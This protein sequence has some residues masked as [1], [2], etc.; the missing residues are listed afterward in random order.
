MSAGK[1]R[2]L[3]P[4]RR[5]AERKPRSG[6]AVVGIVATVGAVV[7][8]TGPG[9]LAYWADSGSMDSGTFGAGTLDLTLDSN[10]GNPT[11]WANTSFALSAMVPGEAVATSFPVQNAGT[12][13]FTYTATATASGALAPYLTF[14]AYV[15]GTATNGTSGGLRTASCSG[16]S[17][18]SLVL[19]GSDQTVIGSAQ[20]VAASASQNVCLKAT[21]ATNAAS[22]AQGQSATATYTFNA[23]QVGA[24]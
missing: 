7:L 11:A 8:L 24:P 6:R 14:E 9:T 2:A 13:T 23:K 5:R 3:K 16:T 21:L 4:G 10:Q 20:T 15:G 12:V 19:T 18:S 22:A 17:M 1:H